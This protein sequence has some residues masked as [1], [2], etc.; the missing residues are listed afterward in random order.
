MI[1]Y[2]ADDFAYFVTTK[3]KAFHDGISPWCAARR[4]AW[5]KKHNVPVDSLT[6]FT[7]HWP[8]F[9]AM[10]KL[11]NDSDITPD[12][13]SHIC[14]LG[15]WYPYTTY[16][17]KS[18]NP[19][20]KIDLYD[21]I[22]R[23]VSEVSEYDVDGVRLIDFN[24]CTESLPDKQYDMVVVSEVLE[25]LPCNI[26]ALCSDISE[27]VKPG[28][29]LLVTYP[30]GGINARDYDRVMDHRD[31]EHLVEE[32]IR[33]FTHETA[34]WFFKDLNLVGS[35]HVEYPAYGLIKICLYQR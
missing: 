25:H 14:E 8:R 12:S 33:E 22:V 5:Q 29:F 27:I 31:Q 7:A 10:L 1:K 32:H 35:C 3:L 26:F 15:S 19:K 16:Y 11:C 18:R 34:D 28:G 6:Y 21:I 2:Y 4:S 9:E 23:E 20:C 13:L 30:L 17:W 24:L